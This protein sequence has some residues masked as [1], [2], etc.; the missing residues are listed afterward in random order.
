MEA[1]G[2]AS[3]ALIYPIGSCP[4]CK[5]D[6][7]SVFRYEFADRLELVIECSSCEYV[8]KFWKT[9]P[10]GVTRT[11]NWSIKLTLPK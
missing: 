6:S 10:Q 1:R 3:Q 4:K 2:F 7:L 9:L 8:S 5:A 11:E